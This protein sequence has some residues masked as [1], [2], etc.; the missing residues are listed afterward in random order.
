MSLNTASGDA[1]LS[2]CEHGFT[3]IL[4]ILAFAIHPGTSES[5]TT[6]CLLDGKMLMTSQSNLG[7]EGINAQFLQE[8]LKALHRLLLKSDVPLDTRIETWWRE[9]CMLSNQLDQEFTKGGVRRNEES[10]EKSNKKIDTA[11]SGIFQPAMQAFFGSEVKKKASLIE[12]LRGAFSATEVVV[13]EHMFRKAP[14]TTGFHG[15]SRILRYLFI[16]WATAYLVSNSTAKRLRMG[17]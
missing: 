14:S 17:K 3:D 15:E 8:K 2:R 10:I 4:E 13:N 7:F 12:D 9:H 6:L 11:W 1:K 5:T 16:R